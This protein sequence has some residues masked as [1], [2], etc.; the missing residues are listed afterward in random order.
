MWRHGQARDL[1]VVSLFFFVLL[2]FLM[3]TMDSHVLNMR[4]D[5]ATLWQDDVLS[6]YHAACEKKTFAWRIEDFIHHL[7]FVETKHAVTAVAVN[8][9]LPSI[10]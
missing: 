9:D 8:F 1:V 6:A 10:K 7:S 5:L 3:I 2:A 4:W